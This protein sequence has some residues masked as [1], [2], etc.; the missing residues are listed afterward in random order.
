MKNNFSEKNKPLMSKKG[1]S[2][3][4]KKLAEALDEKP[5]KRETKISEKNEEKLNTPNKGAA[6]KKLAEVERLKNL[7]SGNSKTHKGGL[8]H[9][10]LVMH[11]CTRGQKH[12]SQHNVTKA[13]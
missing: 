8:L 12:I 11:L 6:S 2:E 10:R 1:I 7:W 3:L 5:T 13:P 4:F 9:S